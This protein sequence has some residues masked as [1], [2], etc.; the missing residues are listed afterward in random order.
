MRV[1]A[2]R[3]ATGRAVPERSLESIAVL[4]DAP[5]S[6]LYAIHTVRG[7]ADRLVSS[8]DHRGPG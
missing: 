3:P 1:V 4:T 2:E 6:R 7:I 5:P 8:R